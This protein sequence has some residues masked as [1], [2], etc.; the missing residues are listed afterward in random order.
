MSFVTNTGFTPWRVAVYALTNIA[1]LV[2]LVR[3]V[4][5]RLVRAYPALTGWIVVNVIS[6]G[7]SWTIPMDFDSYRWFYVVSEGLNLVFF[8]WMVFQ[9]CAGV[10]ESFP[11][12]ASMARRVIQVILPLSVVGSLSLLPFEVTP[13]GRVTFIYLVS[14]TLMAALAV[15]VLLIAAFMVWFRF[16]FIATP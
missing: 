12:T 16:V 6:A 13:R 1:F 15:F 4:S 9:L 7:A 11:G 3:L 8:S 2:L 10:L 5:I 14:R